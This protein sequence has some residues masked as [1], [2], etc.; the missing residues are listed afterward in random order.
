MQELWDDY[1][2][3]NICGIGIPDEKREKGKE[4]ISKIITTEISPN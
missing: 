3:C 4:E 2:W 1:K